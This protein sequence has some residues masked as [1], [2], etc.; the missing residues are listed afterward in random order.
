MKTSLG[1]NQETSNSKIVGTM[2]T[3]E[4]KKLNLLSLISPERED[5]PFM[6]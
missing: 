2:K 4:T 3:M 1:K 6:K 5:I